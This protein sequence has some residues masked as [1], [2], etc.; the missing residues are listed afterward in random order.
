[1]H[2][3][4]SIATQKLTLICS[5]SGW[6]HFEPNTSCPQATGSS[7]ILLFAGPFVFV[8]LQTLKIARVHKLAELVPKKK[9]RSTLCF[10]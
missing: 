10:S 8:Q 6:R 3:F 1:M 7:W 2:F 4:L 5:V 9:E